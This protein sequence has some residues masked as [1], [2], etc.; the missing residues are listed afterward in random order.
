MTS[1]KSDVLNKS[2]LIIGK[3][4][5]QNN[6][7]KRLI[8]KELE[9]PCSLQYDLTTFYPKRLVKEKR[10]LLLLDA[11]Y[12]SIDTFFNFIESNDKAILEQFIIAMFNVDRHKDTER[13]AL[14]KGVRGFFYNDL[15][16]D[17][18]IKGITALFNGELWIKREALFEYFLDEQ[19][20]EYAISS[21]P[22]N[23]TMREI[24][25]LMM[26]S[27]GTK[28]TEIADKLCIST[29]TVKTHLYNIYKKIK[30]PN[31]M[32]AALWAARNL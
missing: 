9:I 19:K 13:Y 29:N 11:F 27:R 31:R 7:L 28:N 12:I 2:V 17:L 4:T 32:Q 16:I 30:V 10:M 1:T 15:S 26:I 3:E 24:E 22:A 25:I 5:I 8:E 21:T 20:Q 18:L 14:K 23:L 6:S